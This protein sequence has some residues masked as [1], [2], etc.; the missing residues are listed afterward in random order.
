MTDDSLADR[1]RRGSEPRQPRMSTQHFIVPVC[2]NC[3]R[4]IDKRGEQ[5][6]HVHDAAK[7]TF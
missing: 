7:V 4:E 3:G 2:G 6:F 5:W 1:I